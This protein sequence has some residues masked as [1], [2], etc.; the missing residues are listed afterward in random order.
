LELVLAIKKFI[1]YENNCFSISRHIF[2]QIAMKNG[3]IQKW[4]LVEFQNSSEAETT[5][6]LL[7][8][9]LVNGHPIRVQVIK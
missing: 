3:V 7:N 8:G 1:C 9:Q 5:M 2:F 4:G 6:D